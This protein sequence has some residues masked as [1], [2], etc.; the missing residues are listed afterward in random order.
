MNLLEVKDLHT[1][2]HTRAGVVRAVNGV[3][4]TLEKGE[5]VAFVGESGSGKSVM[6]LSLVRL[7]P[8][9]TGEIA[10]GHVFFKGKDL[11]ALTEDE[12]RR[13]RGRQ[14]AMVF[15]DPMTSLNPV[16]T[17]GRQLTEGMQMHLGYDGRRSRQ[18]AVEL[19]EQVGIPAPHKRLDDYPHQ[20][21]GGMRQRVMI[22]MALS[23]EPSLILADE[24]TTALDATIQARFSTC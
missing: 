8:P 10:S 15:Q 12:I 9:R 21:S 1:R 16:L 22:A 2:F 6:A 14:I 7:L 13:V 23:C 24:I 20:L 19:L 17:I 18:R 5:T 11:L 3:S 4:F